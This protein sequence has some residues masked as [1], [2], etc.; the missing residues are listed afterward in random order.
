MIL[1]IDQE[2]SISTS[3]TAES[4]EKKV[5]AKNQDDIL[6]SEEMSNA[7]QAAKQQIRLSIRKKLSSLDQANLQAQCKSRT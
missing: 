4:N 2:D 3:I 7:I 5:V 1:S 6:Q